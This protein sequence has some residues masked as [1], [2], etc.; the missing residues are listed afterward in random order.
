MKGAITICL[1]IIA[2]IANGQDKRILDII[3]QLNGSNHV[4]YCR[5]END[6]IP[7]LKVPD[8]AAKRAEIDVYLLGHNISD[9]TNSIQK[10]NAYF[11]NPVK[12]ENLSYY[13]SQ[14]DK[15]PTFNSNEYKLVMNF[16]ERKFDVIDSLHRVEADRKKEEERQKA[17][18]KAIEQYTVNKVWQKLEM[19]SVTFVQQYGTVQQYGY[20]K[21]IEQRSSHKQLCILIGAK[22]IWL[23]NLAYYLGMNE[24]NVEWAEP[25]NFQGVV[26]TATHKIYTTSKAPTVKVRAPY[27]K[28]LQ[29]TSITITGPVDDI[30]KLFI[31][32]W[33]LTDL[34]FN[35]LKTK[36]AVTKDF[37]SDRVSFTWQG[38]QPIITVTK[39][40]DAGMDLFKLK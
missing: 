19:D 30:I 6:S 25:D 28:S 12:Y 31:K 39:N 20:Q 34:S 16:L 32:Y 2:C 18:Q 37:V 9:F 3:D 38:E 8:K 24:Y 1:M 13:E 29:V 35:Q 33:E 23:Y 27:N 40:P 11:E 22:A 7:F 4:S 5:F 21:Q 36:K 14:L 17:E 15:Y 26:L 10:L